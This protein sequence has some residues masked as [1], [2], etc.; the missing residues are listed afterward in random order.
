V[1][2]LFFDNKTVTCAQ[3]ETVLDAFLRQGVSIPFSC[4]NGTCQTCMLKVIKGVVSDNSQKGIKPYLRELGYFLPCK[5]TPESDLVIEASDTSELFDSALVT[6]KEYFTNDIC[7][8]FLEPN[9]PIDYKAGQFINI[10][11]PDGV[12]RSYSLASVASIDYELEIQVK[13]MPGGLVSNW[14]M[15][16]LDEGDMV[17]IQGPHGD[18][19][20]QSGISPQNLLLVGTGTG[21]SPLVGIVRDALNQNHR[22]QIFLYHGASG[23]NNLYLHDYL[24]GLSD[25]NKNFHYTG[26][27]SQEIDNPE[28]SPGRADA[29]AFDNHEDLEGWAVYL[30]GHTEMVETGKERAIAAGIAADNIFSDTFQYR[31]KRK[32]VR[33]PDSKIIDEFNAMEFI[34]E[35]STYPEPDSELWKALDNGKRLPFILEEFYTIVY[36]DERLSPFFHGVTKQRAVEKQYSFLYQVFTGE[37]VY[38]GDRP[39]NAHHW[40][41]ISNE[42]FDYREKIMEGCLRRHG[43]TEKYIARW[44]AMEE[45][46][47]KQIVKTRPWP[48]IVNGIRYPLDGFEEIEISVGSICDGCQSEILPGQK[49]NYHVRLGTIFCIN[50]QGKKQATV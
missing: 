46:Y 36:E 29:I 12:P 1:K 42:L 17:E 43:L 24:N 10:R 20:Y 19:F 49:V 5:G 28:Y 39:R 48:K 3:G 4:R 40:M 35:K 41:V 6:R 2:K 32:R 50:C 31:D 11:H 26:C 21:I 9:I 27:L 23:N 15:D 30:C 25:D 18:C 7:R 22:G 47:R 44:L 33:D 13:R 16:D 34:E 8:V 37:K 38:F 14:I 45:T